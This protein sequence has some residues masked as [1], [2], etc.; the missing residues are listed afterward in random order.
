MACDQFLVQRLYFSRPGSTRAADPQHP[1]EP[2]MPSADVQSRPDSLLEALFTEHRQRACRYARWLVGND[3]DAEEVVQEAFVRLAR[4]PVD[5]LAGADNQQRFT[6]ILFTTVRNLSI[7]LLRKNGRR[8]NISLTHLHEPIV[9]DPDTASAER[10]DQQI[11]KSIRGLPDHWAEALKLK[12]TGE[13]TYQEIA[14]VLGC[15]KAQVRTW[16]FRGRRQIACDLTQ[17]GWLENLQ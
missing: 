2:L 15:S 8:K 1:T 14:D 4:Q 6:G 13:L 5:E 11:Q 7:D 17:T 3:C 9:E 12:I 16:I 10:L